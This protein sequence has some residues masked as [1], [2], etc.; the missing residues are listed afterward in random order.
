MKE[1]FNTAQLLG[2]GHEVDLHALRYSI[3]FDDVTVE[4]ATDLPPWVTSFEDVTLNRI[5]WLT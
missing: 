3:S 5:A 4:C 2:G 1:A